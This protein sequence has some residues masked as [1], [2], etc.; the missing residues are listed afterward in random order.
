MKALIKFLLGITTIQRIQIQD[1]D[2]LIFKASDE[3]YRSPEEMEYML[4]KLKEMFPNN[5]IV[6]MMGIDFVG[7][8]G[9]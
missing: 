3:V 4:T 8:L 5:K 7:A 9:K 6:L 2:Y 1:N